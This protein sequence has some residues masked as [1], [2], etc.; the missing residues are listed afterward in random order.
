MTN[1]TSSRGSGES[2]TIAVVMAAGLVHLQLHQTDIHGRRWAA[3]AGACARAPRR[4]R[5]AGELTGDG[6]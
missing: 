3:H 4:W 5:Q 6:A 2:D 1:G